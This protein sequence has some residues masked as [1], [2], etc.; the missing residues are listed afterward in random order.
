MKGKD[1]YSKICGKI[2]KGETVRV[3]HSEF[4]EG[5]VAVLGADNV[6]TIGVQFDGLHYKKWFHR[7]D[8]TDKRSTYARE[9]VILGNWKRSENAS[10]ECKYFEEGEP[11]P[12]NCSGDGHYLCKTC[13][14]FDPNKLG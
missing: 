5:T 4:G 2:A 1:I 7:E 14:H 8:G 11:R 9:L 12:G 13:K 6:K 10:E 3:K